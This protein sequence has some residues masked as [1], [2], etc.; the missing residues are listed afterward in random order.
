MKCFK[1]SKDVQYMSVAEKYIVKSLSLLFILCR[2][3]LRVISDD[4][5]ARER[6]KFTL[7][8]QEI[9]RVSRYISSRFSATDM[10]CTSLESLKHFVN[11]L[12]YADCA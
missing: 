3:C 8:T 5:R 2:F 11:T 9:L 10:Y 12:F 1:L 4:V 6:T 7:K